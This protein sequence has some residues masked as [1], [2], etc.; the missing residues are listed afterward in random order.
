MQM[1][2][3]KR[4]LRLH[5]E[6]LALGGLQLHLV[7]G[8]RLAESSGAFRGRKSGV[9]TWPNKKH[10]NTNM[11]TGACS[12]CR[13]DCFWLCSSNSFLGDAIWWEQARSSQLG[14]L[15]R[16]CL[17]FLFVAVL[18]FLS[19]SCGQENATNSSRLACLGL[20]DRAVSTIQI[21]PTPLF[22]HPP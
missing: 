20:V 12:G 14:K 13:L 16:I 18:C 11:W 17:G 10:Q 3:P 5:L 7:L 8:H 9:G 21:R 19:F 6:D 22:R 1:R 2:V 15:P 4:C